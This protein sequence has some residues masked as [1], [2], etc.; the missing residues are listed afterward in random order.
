MGENRKHIA[1]IG[2][3][4]AGIGAARHI[5]KRSDHRITV[6][7]DETDHFFSR[8]ALMYIYMGHM[9]YEHTK[10]YE[11][12]FWAK[13]KIDLL[14]AR[15]EKV[16]VDARQLALDRP[17]P[18]GDSSLAFDDLVIA[19]G[20]TSRM[21]GWPGQDLDGVQGL[22]SLPDLEAMERHTQ[23]IER[24]VIVGGG[25]IGVEMAEMLL[26]RKIPVTFLVREGSWMSH[27]LPPEES[28]MICRQLRSHGVDLRLS[29]EMDRIEG[30]AAGRVRA[31][32]TKDDEEIPCQ[33]LGLTI[34]VVPNIDFL[35]GSGIETERGVMV[36]DTL[37]T[38]VPGIYAIGD[39][40]QVREPQPGRRPVEPL[41]Y[42]GRLM[43]ETV[44]R[45]ICGESSAYDPGI[46]FNS[47]K[48]FDIEY[49]V[50]GDI[51]PDP[52]DGVESLYWEDPIDAKGRGGEKSIR[53]NFRTDDQTVIGYNVMGIRYRHELC[54]RWLRE[55]RK[56]RFVLENLGAANFDP[57]IYKEHEADLVALYNQRFPDQPI[58]LKRKRGLASLLAVLGRDRRAA[59][60]T[61]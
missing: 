10:P 5:R 24:A 34:G 19:A 2:N 22:Y 42:T 4:V 49:Q 9:T 46:W 44:A 12:F 51:K 28:S 52:G 1:I 43:G 18:N 16:D 3:G 7:S 57:E 48:F 13:N 31:V 47:A 41:W 59:T 17:G 58:T 27:I 20:S 30:D 14:R 37:E 38:N 33:F 15:V 55:G 54:D 32:V 21:F 35:D 50:Y 53:I 29:T 11:D 26:S 56:L 6:I 39:C 40:A 8:T 36:N 25:L 45:T 23:G 61:A 60:R